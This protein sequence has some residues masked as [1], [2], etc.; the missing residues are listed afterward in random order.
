MRAMTIDDF[1]GPEALR[2]AELP[3]PTPGAGEVLVELAAAGVNPLDVKMRDGSSGKVKGWSAAA[4]PAILGREGVGRV[5]AVGAEVSGF[6]PGDRVIGMLE[7]DDPSGCYAEYVCFSAAG[8]ARIDD[9]LPTPVAAGLSLA[10]L[11]AWAAVHE[12][13]RVQADDIVLVQG[14]GGGTGQLIV[15][16]AVAAGAQVW[17][18]ASARHGERITGYGAHH[19]DYSREDWRAVMP[20]PSVIIDTVYFDVY[21]PELAQLADGG[22]LIILPTLADLEPAQRRGI[23]AQIVSISPDGQRLTKLAELVI[24]GQLDVHVAATYPLEQVAEAHRLVAAGHA[25]GKVILTIN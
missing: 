24:S 16:L 22:R 1:G 15:Q 20:R 10:G 11:T 23:D 18:T 19:I 8:L 21:E 12:H 13:A 6:S 14:G 9:E 17:A 25:G 3:E 4:F 2:P 7:L 5:I